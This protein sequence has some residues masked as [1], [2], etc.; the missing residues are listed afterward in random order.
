MPRYG[1]DEDTWADMVADARA[2]EEREDFLRFCEE[3][4]DDPDDPDALDAYKDAVAY[5]ADPY[6]YYGLRRSDFY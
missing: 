1:Y 4:G 2:E 5:A 6:A 3:H